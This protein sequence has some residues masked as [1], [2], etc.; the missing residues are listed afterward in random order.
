MA[1]PGAPTDLSAE[2]TNGTTI[3]LRWLTP[4]DDGG[5][6]I[7][8]YFIERNLNGAGFATLVADTGNTLVAFSDSTLSARDNAVYRVSAING[9]GTGPTSDTDS[10][11]TAT[12]EAQTIKELLFNNWSLTGELSNVVVGDMNQVV[13]FF[14]RGQIP[15]NKKSKAIVVQ[16]INDLG[17]ENIIEHPKFFEQSDTFEISC[18]LQVPTAADDIFSVWIDLIQ[19][20][21]GEVTR[22]LKTVF[23]PSSTTGEFFRT[24]T[25]WTKDDT[26]APDDA[27]LGR[28]LRFTLTRIVAT[29]EE[30]F[31]GYGGVLAFDT[32]A[33]SGDALPIS[34]FIY[35]EVQRVQTVQGWR[36]IPYITTDSPG[37]IAIPIYYRGAFSGQFS[38]QMFLKKSDIALGTL[39]SLSQIFLPQSNGELGTAVFLQN[40]ENTETIPVLLIES[41]PVNITSI[42]KISET[43]ELVTIALRG[44]LTTSSTYQIIEAIDMAYEDLSLMEYE[45]NVTM[46]YE[47]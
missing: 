4:D 36:N 40:N 32:S 28:T 1:V 38:C 31:L 35:T 27:M 6:A 11:T 3:E 24:N 37:T 19:Q 5:S 43:E 44:N 15:G 23:S 12:S 45:D 47:N 2:S 14:N 10:A 22:I 25:A 13:N 33:S 9:D 46:Q 18:F 42:D 30:V 34:D 21:T 39:N 17:N 41:I 29:T 16:K 20:M 26:F 8:G 7:T